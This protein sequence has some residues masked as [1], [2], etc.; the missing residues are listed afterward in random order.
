MRVGLV[1]LPIGVFL[2]KE[3]MEWVRRVGVTQG[4]IEMVVIEV[5]PIHSIICPGIV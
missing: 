4:D 3:N 2:V 5:K 1:Q